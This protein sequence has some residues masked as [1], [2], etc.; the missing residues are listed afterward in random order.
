MKKTVKRSSDTLLEIANHEELKGELTYQRILHVLG[1]RAFGVV[2][3]FFAL[4]SA[5]PFSA[6]PG[7]SVVFSV[8]II[9]FACQMIFARKTLWLPKIIA[10]RTVHQNTISRVIH[11]TVPWLIKI[12]CFLKPRWSFMTCRFM[13]IINGSIIFCLAILLM[14]PIPLSN[15]IFA[16]LLIIFSLGLIE[17]DGLF[18][19]VG[20]IGAILYVSFIYVFI[21]AIIKHLFMS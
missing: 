13:E 6:I 19:A 11:A 17:K 9:L 20:Y 5:L 1:E 15:F 12:E 14:L 10:E 8:P 7:I 21:V 2:L 3:L 16:G 18:L 4:P